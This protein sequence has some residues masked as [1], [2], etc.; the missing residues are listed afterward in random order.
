MVKAAGGKIWSPYFGD[1]TEAQLKE[2]HDLGLQVGVWTVN[3]PGDIK[4]MLDVGVDGITTDRPDL[5]RQIMAERGMKL[6]VATPVQ[7]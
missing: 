4:K 6:P 7:P 5:L 3:E 1:L 2:A